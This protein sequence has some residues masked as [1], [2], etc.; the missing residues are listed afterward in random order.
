MGAVR[1]T[2][3]QGRSFVPVRSC[4][5]FA[6]S[7]RVA[8]SQ[9]SWLVRLMIV[10]SVSS[11]FGQTLRSANLQVGHE[12][13]AFKDGA[14]PDVTCLAQTNDG[15]LCLCGGPNGLV[16]F[17]GTRFEPFRSPFGDSVETRSVPRHEVSVVAPLVNVLPEVHQR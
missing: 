16:W 15:F 10:I 7:T 1:K 8:A 9:L 3:K 5:V 11:F 2:H 4:D 6:S 17:D 12:S 14:P 13:W